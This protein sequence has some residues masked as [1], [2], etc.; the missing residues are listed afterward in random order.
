M[1]Y[2]R[3]TTIS[4]PEITDEFIADLNDNYMPVIRTF[5]CL[6]CYVVQTGTHSSLMVATYPDK[7]TSDSAA[8]KAAALRAKS[9]EER[10]TE[11]V[12]LEGEVIVTM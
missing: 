1:S 7:A 3:V 9:A 6:D 10:N 4:G 8:E 12:V 2:A 5:G 11:A